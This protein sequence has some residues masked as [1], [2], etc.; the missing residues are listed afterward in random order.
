MKY[1]GM[2][3]TLRSADVAP[4]AGAWIEVKPARIVVTRYQGSLPVRERGLKYFWAPQN[5]HQNHVAPR[6]GAW[7]EVLSGTSIDVIMSVA[8]RAGAWIEVGRLPRRRPQY[9]RRS[10]CGSVD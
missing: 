4:R 9:P 1:D 10:P 8:P 2:K 7:I 5:P 6:A 3:L